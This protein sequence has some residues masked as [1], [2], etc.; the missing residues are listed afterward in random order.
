MGTLLLLK[1]RHLIPLKLDKTEGSSDRICIYFWTNLD[2]FDWHFRFFEMKF[3]QLVSLAKRPK[4]RRNSYFW[5]CEFRNKD[6]LKQTFV[7]L[8]L[9]SEITNSEIRITSILRY[10]CQAVEISFRKTSI[11]STFQFEQYEEIPRHTSKFFVFTLA[12]V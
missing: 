6:H 1:C 4:C 2:P 7:E 11:A 12:L 9:I 3:W 8:I 10:F 5:I